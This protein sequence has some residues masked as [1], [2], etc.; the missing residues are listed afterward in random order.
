MSEAAAQAGIRLIAPD[1]PGYGFSSP[2]PERT[3][4]S[5]VN[6]V[7]ALTQALDIH[8]FSVIGFSMGSLFALV[9]A[10]AL[11]QRIHRLVIVSG[12][13]PLTVENV[14]EGMAPMAAGLYALAGSNPRSLR[15]AMAPLANSAADL[16]ATMAAS[17]APADQVLLAQQSAEFEADFAAA[18]EGGIE[19]IASDFVLAASAWGFCVSDITAK[20]DIWLGEQDS[21]APPAMAQY[22][23]ANMPHAQLFTLPES[24]HFCLYLHWN[25]IVRQLMA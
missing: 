11:P 17:A 13:A 20:T 21:N 19:G 7:E 18:I 8:V 1:R 15:E 25:K 16:F 12:L 24:G 2:H 5:W 14:T 3:L 22:L 23:A 10:Q 6:D 4:A 9:C